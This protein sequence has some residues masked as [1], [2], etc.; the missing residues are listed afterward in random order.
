MKNFGIIL[1]S[2][3][4]AIASMA[5]QNSEPL[6]ASAAGQSNTKSANHSTVAAKPSKSAAKEAYTIVFPQT[7]ARFITPRSSRVV[8]A[9]WPMGAC[10]V[11]DSQTKI[12]STFTIGRIPE[13]L[14]YTAN[15]QCGNAKYGYRHIQA[16]HAEDWKAVAYPSGDPNHWH[17]INWFITE[18][19]K[20]ALSVQEDKARNVYN[21]R[22]WIQIKDSRGRVI[23]NYCP[24]LAI[25]RDSGHRII[26]TYPMNCSSLSLPHK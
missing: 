11:R 5:F 15:L 25:S 18:T 2:T 13:R 9:S 8:T 3:A 1:G 10:G 7:G 14:V 22:G 17:F 20:K 21:Y 16:E 26:T 19:G 24:K 23:K 12:V 6:P 4:F